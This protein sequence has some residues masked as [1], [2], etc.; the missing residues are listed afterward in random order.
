[1]EVQIVFARNTDPALPASHLIEIAIEGD[2]SLG[3]G[4]IERIP[5]LVL[6]PTEQA[7]G[8]ALTG[9]AVPVTDS[10]FWIA[11]SDDSEQQARNLSLLRDGSWFDVP[12]LFDTGRR[13]LLTFEKGI[14]GDRLFESVLAEWEQVQP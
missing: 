4:V 13:A 11:L 5:A 3:T 1:V 6:K 10:L 2:G 12:V 8:Q 9:A 14:P 7:R